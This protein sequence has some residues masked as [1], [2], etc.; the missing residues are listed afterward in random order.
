MAKSLKAHKKH[1]KDYPF[2]EITLRAYDTRARDGEPGL[3]V[4]HAFATEVSDDDG[5]ELGIVSGGT[6]YVVVC[7]WDGGPTF[8][9]P[10]DEIWYAIQKA[11]EAQS[12]KN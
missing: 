2:V 6:G 3:A 8:L 4:F 7:V 12:E 9:I 11:M 10:H 5:K 1:V